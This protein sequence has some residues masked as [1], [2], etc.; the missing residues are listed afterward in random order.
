M[1]VNQ[2]FHNSTAVVSYLVD[3]VGSMEAEVAEA[4]MASKL[5]LTSIV[6]GL[7]FDLF[8][9][10]SCSPEHLGRCV[11]Q[12]ASYFRSLPSIVC[13]PRFRF[14]QTLKGNI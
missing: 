11:K 9:R 1:Y 2:T 14:S 5:N 4:L 6:D 13:L 8:S 7:S 12:R 10:V 3:E